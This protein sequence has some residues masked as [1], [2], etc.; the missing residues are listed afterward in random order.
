MNREPIPQQRI[1]EK[2]DRLLEAQDREGAERHLLYWMQE[3]V[4][5]DDRRGQLLL[6]N[7][8]IGFYRKAGRGE[9]ALAA[10]DRALKLLEELDLTRTRSAGT[11]CVNAA[12]ANS[13]F[14]RPE[15]ALAL[16]EQARAVYEAAPD[17]PR[18]LL[19]GLYN[20]MAVTCRDLG[21]FEQAYGLFD[22]A[23]AA[24]AEVP[25]GVLEMAITCLNRADTIALERGT[26][27][28]EARI[29][30]LLEQAAEYLADPGAARNE[31]YAF[32]CEKCAPGFSYYGW[33]LEAE[34]LEKEA[35]QIRERLGA[36]PG[37][38]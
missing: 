14:G 35:K 5:A 4:N 11:T 9:E 23:M 38:L 18:H 37:V 29:N 20:N 36:V 31:Y 24:M 12:T 7:E 1:M 3:A 10:A 34:E 33:F 8:L 6:N 25:G 32:V 22:L 13:A 19:G 28:G 17:T 26:E 30:A 27:E 16:F 15:R 21:R 2:L